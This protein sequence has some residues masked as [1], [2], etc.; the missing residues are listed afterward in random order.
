MAP[1]FTELAKSSTG[2]VPDQ[3]LDRFKEWE[4]AYENWF[5]HYLNQPGKFW[6]VYSPSSNTFAVRFADEARKPKEHFM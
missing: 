2:S 6:G 3:P 1:A 4:S 5:S